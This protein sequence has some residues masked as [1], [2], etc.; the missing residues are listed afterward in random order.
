MCVLQ[1]PRI[2]EWSQAQGKKSSLRFLQAP[3][4]ALKLI[5]YLIPPTISSEMNKLKNMEDR[6]MESVVREHISN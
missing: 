1:P 5:S 4:E 2:E 3:A 6:R